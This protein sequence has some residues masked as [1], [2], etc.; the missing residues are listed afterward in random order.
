MPT[1]PGKADEQSRSFGENPFPA[2]V[3]PPRSRSR[4]GRFSAMLLASNLTDHRFKEPT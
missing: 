2:T 1:V 4:W 3:A